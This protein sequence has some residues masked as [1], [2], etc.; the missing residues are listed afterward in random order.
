MNKSG[1]ITTL[2]PCDPAF[3]DKDG[4][5]VAM[6]AAM[7]GCIKDLSVEL[8]HDPT[9]RNNEKMT[10]AMFAASYGHI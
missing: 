7:G 6:H 3:K 10:V 1:K 9:I 5:T 8:Y 2:E 4:L